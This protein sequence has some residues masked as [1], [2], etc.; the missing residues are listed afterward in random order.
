[1]YLKLHNSLL[2]L[3]PLSS[4]VTAAPSSPHSAKNL[5]NLPKLGNGE[6]ATQPGHIVPKD[7]IPAWGGPFP[8]DDEIQSA[9][10]GFSLVL[11]CRFFHNESDCNAPQASNNSLS[12]F[13]D[14]L[15]SILACRLVPGGQDCVDYKKTLADSI[16]RLRGWANYDAS[17]P[18]DHTIPKRAEPSTAEEQHHP[19]FEGDGAP[20]PASVLGKLFDAII[21][22]HR[23]S[24]ED[25][26]RTDVVLLSAEEAINPTRPDRIVPCFGPKLDAEETPTPAARTVG[27]LPNHRKPSH[28]TAIP[29]S[30]SAA[31]VPGRDSIA[32]TSDMASST[33]ASLSRRALFPNL[34]A[35]AIQGLV[36]NAIEEHKAK[37]KDDDNKRDL[38]IADASSSRRALLPNLAA[39]AIQGLVD[40]AIEEHKNKD[41][42]D[43]KKRDLS[44]A[45]SSLSR[46]SLIPNLAAGAIQGLVDNAIEEHKDKDKEDDKK[47]DLSIVD[48]SLSERAFLPNLA[49]GAIQ[50]LVDNA[51]EEHKD[52]DKDD[53]EKRDL[54]PRT[55]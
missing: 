47:R 21:G 10:R 35:T 13:P 24:T 4:L 19:K 41:K 7:N 32:D 2:A 40:N 34:A 14:V 29:H 42:D 50:G 52:K 20:E 54:R 26:A 44:I 46:K 43:D 37:D 53:E 22:R 36:D 1:M 9:I 51:I 38:S 3:L 48:A 25:V 11:N 39:T 6:V 49:A 31:A 23:P 17:I 30:P 28:P 18:P 55:D 12:T 27:V 15:R 16:F 8:T 33:D 45:D 5:V